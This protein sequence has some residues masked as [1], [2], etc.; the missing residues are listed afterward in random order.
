MAQ[1]G[2]KKW[3]VSSKQVVALE[4]LAFSYEQVADENTSTED[5][6]TT[7][8]RGTELFPL[9]FTTVLHS[10]AGVDVWAEIQSWKALVTK[11]NY[12][13]LGG[14]KLGPKLQ[15]R[16]VAVSN[17][18]VDG[19]GRLLLGHSFLH[20]QGIRSGHHQREGKHHRAECESE[21]RLEVRQENNQHSG[22][23][24][25]KENDQSRR[26]CEADRQQVRNRPEDTKLGK[27][28]KA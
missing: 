26:L 23:K 21:H 5:K 3:A 13:Y 1:W 18:K 15:L 22:Q 27:T 4:G 17:T 7:N 28:T 8:E 2:S 19:K 11:V 12:F 20:I 14:K 9:S 6:K 10:G 16:K 24:G 25:R